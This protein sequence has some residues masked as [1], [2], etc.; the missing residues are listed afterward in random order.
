MEKISEMVGKTI[1]SIERGEINDEENNSEVLRITF[2]DGD[3]N[4]WI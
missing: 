1:Q 3:G 2:S 4:G